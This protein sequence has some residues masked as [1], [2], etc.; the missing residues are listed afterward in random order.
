VIESVASRMAVEH[1]HG[2]KK[3]SLEAETELSIEKKVNPPVKVKRPAKRG[4][5]RAKSAKARVDKEITV[6]QV[7]SKPVD[8]KE[9]LPADVDRKQE[10]KKK[11]LIEGEEKNAKES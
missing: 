8:E 2:V 11:E 10:E 4:K 9:S 7:E 1:D 3:D 5:K 6:L